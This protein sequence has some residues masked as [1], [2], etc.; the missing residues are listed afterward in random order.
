MTL[1]SLAQWIQ[2]SSKSVSFGKACK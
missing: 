1:E 2:S